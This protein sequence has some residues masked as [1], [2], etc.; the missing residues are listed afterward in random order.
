MKQIQLTQGKY[1]L[2]DDED[3]EWL[4]QWKWYY[5]QSGYACRQVH[6]GYIDGKQKQRKIY[7]HKEI[8]QVKGFF[9]D[10]KNGNTLDNRRTNLRAATNQQNQLNR[11]K[12]S[13]NRTG[14]KGVYPTWGGRWRARLFIH[15]KGINGGTYD[16][17]EE[18]ATAYN[19]IAKEHFGEFA[20]INEVG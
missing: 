1:A 10:H 2:V 15:R 9:T 5:G 20:Q 16:T 19:L 18:A 17:K 6:Q 7:M 12:P 4:N 14:Y 13:N 11:G 3:F 8:L